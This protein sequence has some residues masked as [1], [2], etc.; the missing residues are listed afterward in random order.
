MGANTASNK[1]SSDT[2]VDCSL[3][4]CAEILGLLAEFKDLPALPKPSDDLI[5]MP[6]PSLVSKSKHVPSSNFQ[7]KDEH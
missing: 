2:Q 4:Q 5:L 6:H 7:R 1:T 3:S